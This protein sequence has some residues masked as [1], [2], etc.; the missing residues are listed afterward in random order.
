MIELL[1]WV[2]E[3]KQIVCLVPELCYLTGL[4]SGMKSDF[5]AMKDIAMYTRITPN[6]RQG[7]LKKF[8]RNIQGM[9]R[10]VSIGHM[11]YLSIPC[12]Q[13]QTLKHMY[14]WT[15]LVNYIT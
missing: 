12:V 13:G 5:R 4:T 1:L 2:Q 3:V 9:K 7:A 15:V 14:F 11:H 8:I 6:Q 10:S